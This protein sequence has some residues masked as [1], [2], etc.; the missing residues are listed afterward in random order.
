MPDADMLSAGSVGL[1]KG[2]SRNLTDAT[3]ALLSLGYDN[4]SI[5]RAVSGIDT[6]KCDVGEIV[7]LALKKLMR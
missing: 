4:A 3:E 2:V 1:A 7:R 5:L 6:E